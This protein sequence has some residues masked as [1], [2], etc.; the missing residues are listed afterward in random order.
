MMKRRNISSGS[1]WEPLVGYSRAVRVGRHVRVAGTTA[2]GPDGEVQAPGDPYG[3][4]VFIL[5]KIRDAL[6]E[7]GGGL[8][9]VVATRMYVT[10]IS[11]WQEVGRAHS[12][13][14]GKILPAATMVEVSSLV[15]PEMA[16]E[17]E[18]EAILGEE[19]GS[20]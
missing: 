1:K 9:D 19:A 6:R 10:D 15:T 5:E 8:E 13:F 11:R 16:V 7:A 18:V 3:Q 14:F 12:E 4:A 2:T 17:I 20:E